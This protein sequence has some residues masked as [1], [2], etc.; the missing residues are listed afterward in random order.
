MTFTV[1]T[2]YAFALEQYKSMTLEELNN[3]DYSILEF[4]DDYYIV[5]IDGQFYF[6]PIK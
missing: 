6:V 4:G 3:H 1:T 2:N 5:E